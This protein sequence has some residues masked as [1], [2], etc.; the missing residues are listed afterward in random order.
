MGKGSPSLEPVHI[1]Y[2]DNDYQPPLELLMIRPGNGR[3]ADPRPRPAVVWIHGGGWSSGKPEVFL[4]H[5]RY[6]AGR[7]AVCFSVQYRLAGEA[8]QTDEPE[9]EP[10]TEKQTTVEDCLEDCRAAIRFIRQHAEEFGI[11]PARIAVAGDSAGGHLAV[12]LAT[13]QEDDAETHEAEVS[14]IPDAVINLNAVTDLTISF[15]SLPM[16]TD[17]DSTGGESDRFLR[18]YAQAKKLSPVFHAAP[19]QPPML[20]LHG[21]LDQTVKPEQTIRMHEAYLGV[22]N[23]SKLVLFENSKHAFI[24][25]DY[26]AAPSEIERAL[27]CIDEF[28]TTDLGWLDNH[29]QG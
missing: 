22:G 25:Y 3:P 26:T 14:G 17:A 16:R 10:S 29:R 1:I 6:F 15:P 19:G 5:C 13:V 20:H 18:R 27:T 28:L 21:L 2:T 11:H 8:R 4:P 24:L 12:C 7:G 9:P 23:V